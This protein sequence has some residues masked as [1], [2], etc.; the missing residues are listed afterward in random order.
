MKVILQ[1]EI[2]ECGLASLAMVL[3]H[4]GYRNTLQDLRRRFSLS[5][6][7]AS[8]KSVMG[9]AQSLGFQTRALRL[10]MEEITQLKTPCILHWD[11]DH[12]VTLAKAA[13]TH[14][15]IYDPASG[16]KKLSYEEASRHFTGVALE[17]IP[18]VEFKKQ[19]A[20]DSVS[21]SQLTGPVRGLWPSLTQILLLS[22]A[23]QVFVLLGPFFMQWVVDQALVSADKDLLTVMGLGFGLA[24]LL[25]IVIG[26]LR[27]WSVVYLSS[28]LGLQWMGNVFAHT[29]KLPLDFFEKRHLGDVVSRMGA[30][31]AI[32]R[33]LTTSALEAV[34]DGLMAIA[35][36]AMMLIYSWKLAMVTFVAVFVYFC[37]RLLA[38]KPIRDT[39]EQHLVAAAKQQSH[40]LESLRGIQSVKVSGQETGRLAMYQN[41]MVD[42]VNQE[43]RIA[44]M[45]LG[46]NTASQFVFGIERIVVIWLGASL[47]MQSIFS[48][49]M[50]IA[51]LAYKDQFAMRISSLIDKWIEFRMLRLH[52]ER[53][54]DV[55]LTEPERD[56]GVDFEVAAPVST[57]IKVESLCFRYAEAEP[58]VLKDLRFTVS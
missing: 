55:V 29:L 13:K 15:T 17:L 49:G 16:I 51:Y 19:K 31:Q 21:I 57:E 42:T 4:Y 54:A 32:Q 1:T 18:G 36:V 30:V 3:D 14:I 34:I 11:L 52:G 56:T 28:R 5:L 27:G 20:P 6:K 23:L 12:Y 43:L 38:F 22:I 7:G 46:F 47:A 35:T 9:M 41:L 25:Q 37:I 45:G 26:L 50:L 24:L 33:T 8:L 40:L 39:T 44:R 53:L 48:V 58:W 2:A 10:D